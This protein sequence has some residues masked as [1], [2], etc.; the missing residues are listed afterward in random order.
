MFELLEAASNFAGIMV[1]MDR[2]LFRDWNYRMSSHATD[3]LY[4]SIRLG[5]FWLE[6]MPK[7]DDTPLGSVVG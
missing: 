7:W 5:G 1:S 4:K 3:N 2:T 6:T